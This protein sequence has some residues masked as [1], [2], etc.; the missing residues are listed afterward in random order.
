VYKQLSPGRQPM[1][2]TITTINLLNFS[3]APC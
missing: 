1:Q 3:V 2:E